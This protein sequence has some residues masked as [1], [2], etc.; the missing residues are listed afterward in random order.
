MAADCAAL[1][2][3]TLQATAAVTDLIMAGASGIFES[4]DLFMEDL[5]AVEE[6]RRDDNTPTL[7]LAI[8]VQDSGMEAR[9]ERESTQRVT[10]WLYDRQR[11]Y[12]NIRTVRKQVYSA[13]QDLSS[14]LTDPATGY[15]ALVNLMI[16][17]R[18]GHRHDHR[19]ALDF[20]SM[21]FEGLVHQDLT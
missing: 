2:L 7:L 12:A 17:S 3:A 1:A 11:G 16:A 20:E 14:P 4:G 19:M 6:S 13:L 18:T 9:N 21:R 15:T 5:A 8:V 10:V